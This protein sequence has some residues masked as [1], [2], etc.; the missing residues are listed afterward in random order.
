MRE[1]TIEDFKAGSILTNS[2]GDQYLIL[3]PLNNGVWRASKLGY[4][5]TSCYVYESWFYTVN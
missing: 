5:S 1:A 3:N 2:D 4:M